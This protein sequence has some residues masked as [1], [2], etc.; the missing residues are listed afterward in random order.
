ME[1]NHN[2]AQKEM[3]YKILIFI[4]NNIIHKFKGNYFLKLVDLVFYYYI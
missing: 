1:T 3:T 4:N 2:T